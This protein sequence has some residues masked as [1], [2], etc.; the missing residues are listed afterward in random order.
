M[1][2]CLVA[3]LSILLAT[4]AGL[5]GVLTTVFIVEVVDPVDLWVGGATFASGTAS[6]IVFS[7]DNQLPLN[8]NHWAQEL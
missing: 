6:A 4:V 5:L 7:S 3:L 8:D 2:E 1:L